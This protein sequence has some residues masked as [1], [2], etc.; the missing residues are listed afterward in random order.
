[1]CLCASILFYMSV[2]MLVY[3]RHATVLVFEYLKVFN[4]C[5]CVGACMAACVPF[6]VFKTSQA[7]VFTPCVHASAARAYRL[8]PDSP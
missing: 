2:F 3:V 6:F 1:M 4:L 5:L 8:S 7:F